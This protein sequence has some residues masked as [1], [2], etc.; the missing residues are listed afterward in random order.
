MEEL[1]HSDIYI[2]TQCN[3]DIICACFLLTCAAV[4]TFRWEMH[5]KEL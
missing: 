3:S 1:D 5:S 4:Q 2:I